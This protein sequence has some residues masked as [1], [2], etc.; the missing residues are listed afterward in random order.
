MKGLRD[1]IVSF[2]DLNNIGEILSERSKGR[3]HH[4]RTSSVGQRQVHTLTAHEEVCF[5][6]DSVLLL[7][8]VDERAESFK[9]GHG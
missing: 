5:W 9:L 6:Q 8:F 2:I 4:A 3:P 7:A 1:C